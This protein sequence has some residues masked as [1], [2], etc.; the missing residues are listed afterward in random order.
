MRRRDFITL[1][2][3][4]AATWPIAALAQRA[5][6]VVAFVNS[7][8]PDGATL[9]AFRKGLNETGYIE[10]QNVTVEYHWLEGQYE[11]LPSVMADIVRRRVAVIAAPGSTPAALAA[12]AATTTIPIVFVVNQDPVTLGLVASL[13][14]PGGNATGVNAL[15]VE[16]SAKRLGLLH[17]LVP[18]AGRVALLFN[19]AVASTAETTLRD[20]RDAALALKLDIIP[21]EAGSSRQIEAAF[22]AIVRAQADALVVAP[23]QFFGNRRV[24]I[25]T[26][27]A[28]HAIPTVYSNRAFVEV[29]GLMSYGADPTDV[30]R[31]SGGY[32]G[33]I[34]KGTKPAEL[35]VNQS[36]KFELLINLATASAIDLVVPGDLL[37]IADEVIE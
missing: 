28:R 22:A 21:F 15:A 35:P 5:M 12:K 6:P 13:A 7:G 25:A 4:A 1:L 27:A 29:G 14:R 34:L 11:R 36:S 23:N 8:S 37:S 30:F 16:V 9:T 17:E 18:K 24:Q 26:L 19:P 20:T 33:R 10:G 2:G 3:G 31:Q 32:T